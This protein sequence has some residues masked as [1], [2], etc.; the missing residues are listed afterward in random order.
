[1]QTVSY[2]VDDFQAFSQRQQIILRPENEIGDVSTSPSKI[3]LKLSGDK[4]SCDPCV[5]PPGLERIFLEILY[6]AVDN[7]IKSR[8]EGI[9]TEV[10]GADIVVQINGNEISVMN[11]GK[12][13]PI[14]IK[15][16]RVENNTF[17][18][19][20]PS[21]NFGRLNVSSNYRGTNAGSGRNGHG[22]KATNIFSSQFRVDIVNGDRA[23][24]QTWTNRM[25]TAHEPQVMQLTQPMQSTFNDHRSM[26]NVTF[27]PFWPAFMV[28][29]QSAVTYQHA[30]PVQM[31][32]M[33]QEFTDIIRAHAA[34]TS[35]ACGC[36][37]RFI[38]KN[39]VTTS[40]DRIFALTPEKMVEMMYGKAKTHPITVGG[41]GTGTVIIVDTPM[42]NDMMKPNYISFV[43]GLMLNIM[44]KTTGQVSKS[45][46]AGEHINQI[47]QEVV[48][49]LKDEVNNPEVQIT[50]HDVKSISILAV[51]YV[52][53]PVFDGHKKGTLQSYEG[54]LVFKMDQRLSISKWGVFS[55]LKEKLLL[56][57]KRKL[58][59]TDG[60][61]V[62]H[63]NVGELRD[64][65]KAGT[66]D[67]STK[68]SLFLTEGKSGAGY[69]KTWI[70]IKPQ[71][72]D[73]FGYLPLRGKVIN[74][75]VCGMKQLEENKE[76][77]DIKTALGLQ[78]DVD[79]SVPANR[80]KLRYGQ[81]IIA[82]DAD[83]DGKHIAG[84]IMNLFHVRFPSLLTSNF[85]YLLRT[86]MIR[87]THRSSKRMQCFYS[88]DEFEQYLRQQGALNART[89]EVIYCKGLGSS[90]KDMIKHDL[91]DLRIDV[92]SADQYFS[93]SMSLAFG[94][95]GKGLRK[96]WV[97][98]S[99]KYEKQVHL[100]T[101][102]EDSP[103]WKFM[104]APSK[105]RGI[106]YVTPFIHHELL[107]YEKTSVTRA[108]PGID[109]LK[110][111]QRKIMWYA[112]KKMKVGEKSKLLDIASSTQK[113]TQY[114]HGP[115]SLSKTVIL[116][117]QRFVGSN[118]IPLFQDGGMF[119]TRDAA[120]KDAA[121]PRYLSCSLPAYMMKIFREEDMIVLRQMLRQEEGFDIEP[122]FLLPVIPLSLVNAKKGVATGI[123]TNIIQFNPDHI[124][125][126][127]LHRLSSPPRDLGMISN[128]SHDS[129][130]DETGVTVEPYYWGYHGSLSVTSD[131]S[132]L[133][134]T[135][136]GVMTGQPITHS[137]G[138]AYN[139]I[140]DELPV[141]TSTKAF[142]T[143]LKEM[144]EAKKL[145]SYEI[146][147]YED[148]KKIERVR[149]ILY[150]LT[151]VDTLT[152][153]MTYKIRLNSLW[154]L[155]EHDTPMHFRDQYHVL[156]HFYNVRL[157]YYE[158]RRKLLIK[159][160]E[161]Q[162]EKLLERKAAIDARINKRVI[163]EDR[164]DVKEQCERLGISFEIIDELKSRDL[165]KS[166]V[167]KLVK[168]IE[169][170]KSNLA[171]LQSTTGET[172]WTR[173]LHELR[174]VCGPIYRT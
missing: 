20:I 33:T 13:I 72:S 130:P 41:S 76:Y 109:G 38:C 88:D 79:Y 112:L 107:I 82:S 83:D 17:D 25:D 14:D 168:N 106:T 151:D 137:T 55:Q 77:R 1:M 118:N 150:N 62:R 65:N 27:T 42:V 68:C 26:I 90:D 136:L 143:A 32:S 126:W 145:E 71:G 48:R 66:R 15:T 127:L 54:K 110:E 2:A 159:Q 161:E 102:K 164:D 10:D 12:M 75:A 19:W 138:L 85:I 157:H 58:K 117:A 47:Q 28:Y 113:L 158:V 149:I 129:S 111:S 123:S 8:L 37:V 63:V 40:E 171:Q 7:L 121:Q 51:L 36:R 172:M 50:V 140:V 3:Y 91:N 141:K 67:E 87:V 21:C 97:V 89:Y 60:R 152:K 46:S 135:N 156:E 22:A 125:D 131:T 70:T 134:F 163:V 31:T 53:T 43:N 16:W 44:G 95:D 142:E 69:V 30:G 120:G 57:H 169:D 167:A 93:E 56:S 166:N 122:R 132:G 124:I 49:V 81:I 153:L 146:N 78:E 61:K 101:I 154:L 116:M 147:S 4:F 9:P 92:V 144:I 29:P 59:A 173:E 119:G 6:N 128:L 11:Y 45:V 86:P 99:I 170:I 84:L 64:A 139:V 23:F 115:D 104:Q 162:L 105:E 133:L 103:I 165:Y 80:A 155:D 98:D 35:M 52:T 24:T 148:E 74:V 5:T 108:I 34:V 39:T 94:D 96:D 100:E 114:R 73:Y 160:T 18:D 174:D